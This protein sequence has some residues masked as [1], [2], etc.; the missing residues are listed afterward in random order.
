MTNV[1]NY[2]KYQ[3]IFAKVFRSRSYYYQYFGDRLR[4][5]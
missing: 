5:R 1:K 3:E 2:E 4:N